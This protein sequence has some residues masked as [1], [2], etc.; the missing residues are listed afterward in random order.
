MG[1]DRDP[2]RERA[3]LNRRNPGNHRRHRRRSRGPWVV[4][5]VVAVLSVVAAMLVLVGLDSPQQSV[6]QGSKTTPEPTR[7]SPSM[8]T[9]A[10][11]P[12][13]EPVQ[14]P[15]SG[16]GAFTVAS[17]SSPVAGTS[18]DITTYRVEVENDL[19]YEADDFAADVDRTL[20][21]KRGWTKDGSHSFKRDADGPL[22]VVL[23]SPATTDALCAPLQTRGEVSCRN[24]NVVAINAVRWARGAATFD[25]D[26]STYRLYVINHEIGH[27]L[28]L[29]HANCP[30][31]GLPA[32][33]M[34]Q[35]TI[36]LDGCTANPW[37]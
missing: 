17:G 13:P 35:Q 31:P 6:A 15:R 3:I 24:G 29:G 34:L 26:V 19:P 16:S 33:V 23:A 36:N 25:D 11:S 2:R 27:S 18:S 22:R 28:G 9:P 7:P 8:T 37:P 4:G 1:Q 10:P 21:D 5:P 32:P 20:A 30:G 14:I 12:T